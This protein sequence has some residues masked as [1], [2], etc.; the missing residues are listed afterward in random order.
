MTDGIRVRAARATDMGFIV[1][2]W[3]NTYARD[4]RLC[5]FDRDLYYRLMGKH[6]STLTRDPEAAFLVACSEADEDTLA[7]FA[8]ITGT[9]L[10]YVFVRGGTDPETHLRR[11][12]IARQLLQ[13][14]D[15][16]TFTFRTKTGL[17]RLKPEERGW[18]F[19]PHTAVWADGTVRVEMG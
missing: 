17:D 8:A 7:G 3:R 4:A 2:T 12:G 1:D 16:K 13:G 19:A 6:I 18:T 11:Q 9:A 5:R 10:H 14:R 15:I